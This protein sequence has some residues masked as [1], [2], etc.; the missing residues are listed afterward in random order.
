MANSKATILAFGTALTHI[1]NSF[2]NLIYTNPLQDKHF[3]GI[4][5]QYKIRIPSKSMKFPF[6]SSGLCYL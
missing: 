3:L 4:L 2:K 5:K 6:F 1:G